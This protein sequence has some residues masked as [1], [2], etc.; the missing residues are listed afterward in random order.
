MGCASWTSNDNLDLAFE[1]NQWN[2]PRMINI[3]WSNKYHLKYKGPR[4]KA[5]SRLIII[6]INQKVDNFYTSKLTN[7]ND[8]SH[9]YEMMNNRSNMYMIVLSQVS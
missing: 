9:T 8:L 1:Y 7:K 4:N 2:E 3:D 5:I 6:S